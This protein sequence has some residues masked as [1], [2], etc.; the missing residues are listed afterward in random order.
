MREHSSDPACNL[1]HAA[2]VDWEVNL[3][4]WGLIDAVLQPLD[5]CVDCYKKSIPAHVDGSAIPIREKRRTFPDCLYILMEYC[6]STL[7]EAVE[8]IRR[9]SGGGGMAMPPFGICSVKCW[10][11]SLICTP[12]GSSIAM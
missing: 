10:K 12:M 4:Q 9:S 7:S 8:H 11:G 3:E 1:C 6:E 5:L 2:Y